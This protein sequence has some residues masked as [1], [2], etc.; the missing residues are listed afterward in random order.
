[1]FGVALA[2]S[3]NNIYLFEQQLRELRV[4]LLC[5]LAAVVAGTVLVL[6]FRGVLLLIQASLK[7]SM[8]NH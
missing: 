3:S 6:I 1:M 8:E 4:C 5:F 7:C 2:K